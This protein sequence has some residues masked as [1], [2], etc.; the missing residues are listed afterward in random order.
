MPN[1][2]LISVIIP[3]HNGEKHIAKCL[4]ALIQSN[5]PTFEIIL[6][7]DCSTDNTLAI[8]KAKGLSV[9]GTKTRSGPAVARNLGAMHAQ[10][11]ILLFL[12]ADIM[13]RKESLALI[14]NNFS[15]NPD[16]AALFGSYDDE[17]EA[18]NFLSQYRNLF[19][20]FI[21]QTASV[22]AFSFWAGCGAIKKKVFA[23]IGGFDGIR[24]RRA[25]IEDIELGYRLKKKGYRILLVKELQVK[26]L[27]HWD[28][29][30]ILKTD[31]LQRAIP[32]SRLI[33]ETKAMPKDLNLKTSHRINALFAGL[34]MLL[35][36]IIILD[37]I[38]SYTLSVTPAASFLLFIVFINLLI[39][40]HKLY[41]FFARKRGI[42]FAAMAV[43]HQVLYYLYAGLSFAHIWISCKFSRLTRVTVNKKIDG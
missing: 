15:R 16:I 26:H 43:P 3:V 35:S 32:W 22:N 37:H 21:H 40:D 17:P 11:D 25:S 30:S 34:L 28:F 24:Y 12:D 31:I 41:F 8:A 27:K 13:V 33:I 42:T 36:I 19:H 14:E 2:P 29:K 18:G 1:P 7:D 4:E 23:E 10:G 6:V 39:L 38:T 9:I 5:Y 20:H